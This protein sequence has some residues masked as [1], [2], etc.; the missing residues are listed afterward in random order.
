MVVAAWGGQRRGEL[1]RRRLPPM[2][3]PARIREARRGTLIAAGCGVNS[4]V[5]RKMGRIG[6]MAATPSGPKAI[7]TKFRGYRFRSRLEAR[8]AVLLESLGIEWLYEP[9]GFQL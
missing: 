2:T 4:E 9:E 3:R 7:E 1:L 5:T 8:W 6:D